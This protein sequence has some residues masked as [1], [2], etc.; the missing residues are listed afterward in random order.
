[1]TLRQFIEFIL[2]QIEAAGEVGNRQE[3]ARLLRLLAQAVTE[4]AEILER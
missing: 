4:Q 2:P 3:A 1:M